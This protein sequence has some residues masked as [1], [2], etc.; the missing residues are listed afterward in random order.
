MYHNR[1]NW[2]TT[3]VKQTAQVELQEYAEGCHTGQTE[4]RDV[5]QPANVEHEHVPIPGQLE[6]K[7]VPEPGQV[8]N[9]DVPQPGEEEHKDLPHPMQ[10]EHEGNGNKRFMDGH[11]SPPP[12]PPTF[13]SGLEAKSVHWA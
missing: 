12:H 8:E 4:H 7:D 2:S 13:P 11:L 10:M 3:N 6:H 5:P 9:E 1:D